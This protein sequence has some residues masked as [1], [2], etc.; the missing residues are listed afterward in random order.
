MPEDPYQTLGL[1]SGATAKEVNRAF[2]RLAKQH[3]PDLNP[4]DEAAEARFL[5][6]TAAH[7]YLTNQ[8]DGAAPRFGGL[9]DRAYA[10]ELEAR[11]REKRGAPPPGLGRKF[12]KIFK[13]FSRT[14]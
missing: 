13:F 2:R 11:L 4:G 9:S 14:G 10:A 1:S 7:D 6:V 3:H 5:A 12:R 8:Q